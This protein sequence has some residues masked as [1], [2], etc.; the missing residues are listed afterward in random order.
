MTT[1]YIVNNLSAQTITGKVGIGV[2]IP[3]KTLHIS[4]EA[5]NDSGLRL[6]R[7]TSSRPI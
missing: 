2:E 4:G 6:E 1:K 3:T 7:L 5:E